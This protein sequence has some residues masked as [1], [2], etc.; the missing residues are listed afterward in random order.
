[1]SSSGVTGHLCLSPVS[2][3]L[4]VCFIS[5]KARCGINVTREWRTEYS[6]VYSSS[7]ASWKT[8]LVFQWLL[9]NVQTWSSLGQLGTC[10]RPWIIH[11]G[12]R[13][14]LADWPVLEKTPTSELGR[15]FVPSEVYTNSV[16]KVG[17]PKKFRVLNQK[18]GSGDW[19][20]GWQYQSLTTTPW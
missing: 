10:I 1:M 14:G 6:A 18:K 17:P 3:C 13:K 12:Q 4:W 9:Q 15:G 8:A 19:R 2:V 11:C 5:R 7:L 16:R 20:T